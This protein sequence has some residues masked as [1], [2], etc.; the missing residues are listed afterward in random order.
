MID[1]VDVS[2]E[3]GDFIQWL[4]DGD[5]MRQFWAGPQAV[6][7]C[8][9]HAWLTYQGLPRCRVFCGE[10]LYESN[11]YTVHIDLPEGHWMRDWVAT[12]VRYE[13]R[14]MER[15]Q[16]LA[17]ARKIMEVRSAT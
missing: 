9:L 8:A 15:H 14:V 2:L 3:L 17:E 7:G 13:R 4:A 5:G 11:H 6:V 10:I 12:I 1:K 16:A